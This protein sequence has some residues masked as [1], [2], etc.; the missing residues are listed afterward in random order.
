MKMV[1]AIFVLLFALI[2][3]EVAL[4]A[5]TIPDITPGPQILNPLDT[6]ALIQP[7]PTTNT[8]ILT[9]SNVT[10]GMN[11]V[12]AV[13]GSFDP[14]TNP[15][16]WMLLDEMPAQINGIATIQSTESQMFFRVDNQIGL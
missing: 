2:L 3:W 15:T 14:Y 12:T 8:V 4:N 16:N 13:H 10:V 6:S 9:W 7:F 1:D 5:Q 11:W